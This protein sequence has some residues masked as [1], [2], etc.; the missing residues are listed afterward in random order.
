[1]DEEL[2]QFIFSIEMLAA[3]ILDEIAEYRAIL[4]E[5]E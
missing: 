3:K 1:M 4:E 5:Q 2:E